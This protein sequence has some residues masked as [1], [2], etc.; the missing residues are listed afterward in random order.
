MAGIPLYLRRA[1]AVATTVC[2]RRSTTPFCCGV[3]GAE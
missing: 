2:S 1:R 3:Y